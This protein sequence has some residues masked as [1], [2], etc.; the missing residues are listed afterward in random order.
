MVSGGFRAVFSRSA[1][2]LLVIF[3]ERI[4]Q[5]N[6]VGAHLGGGYASTRPQSVRRNPATNMGR[7]WTRV[8]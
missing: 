2:D 5:S 3:I 6:F 4:R 7:C 8:I 1:L